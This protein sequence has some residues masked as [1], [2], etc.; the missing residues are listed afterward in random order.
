MAK[1]TFTIDTDDILR[2]FDE[3][4]ETT[5]EGLFTDALRKQITENVWSKVKGDQ[6]QQFMNDRAETIDEA[7]RLK[8]ESFMEEDIVLTGKWG[9]KTFVGTIEDY[10]KKRLDEKLL[11]P[12]NNDGAPTGSCSTTGVTWVQWKIER[13]MKREIDRIEKSCTDIITK[14]VGESIKDHLDQ[15]LTNTVND[16]VSGA[17]AQI[18]S[19]AA[20]Q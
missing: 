5:F 6:F 9:E 11:L 2:D 14:K 7:I 4:T 19:K 18:L 1:L 3:E 20:N 17:L 16:K 15:M 12:V 10:I 8:F 13:M